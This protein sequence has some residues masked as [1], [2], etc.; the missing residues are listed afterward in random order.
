[1]R[2]NDL[3]ANYSFNKVKEL[4]DTMALEGSPLAEEHAL[5]YILCDLSSGYNP[6][7]SL[8]Q[9]K[10]VLLGDSHMNSFETILEKKKS[11]ILGKIFMQP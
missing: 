3:P 10:L 8:T 2:K 7:L 11:L 6:A 9:N 4:N 1:M 5:S